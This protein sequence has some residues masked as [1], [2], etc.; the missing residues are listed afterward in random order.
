MDDEN[1]LMYRFEVEDFDGENLDI[2]V[3]YGYRAYDDWKRRFVL[4]FS[5]TFEGAINNAE[6]RAEN[7]AYAAALFDGTDKTEN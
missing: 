5:S 1:E 4:F 3:Q 7:Y 2:F 6:I